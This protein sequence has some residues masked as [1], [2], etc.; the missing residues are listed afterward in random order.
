MTKKTKKLII[1][2]SILVILVGV[3]LMVLLLNYKELNFKNIKTFLNN[4][5]GWCIVA[6]FVCMLV[7]IVAEGFAIQLIARRL[8]HKTKVHQ[9]L[10][11]STAD[12]YY[13]A[14][15]PSSSGGQP[16]SLFYM[17]RDGMSVGVAGF[18]LVLNLLAYSSAII[19]IG[20]FAFIAGPS[21]FMRVDSFL[22]RVLIIIGFVF[23][24]LLL[25]LILAC[26][27]FS[28]VPRKI[29]NA[30]IKLGAKMHIIKKPQKWHDKWN[31]V[32]EK[33]RSCRETLKKHWVLILPVL[34]LNLLQRVAQTLTPCFVCHAA[35][36]DTSLYHLF[37]VQAFVLLGYNSL[38]LPGG[39]GAFEYLY[40]N[41]YHAYFNEAFIL[42][43]MMVSRVISF[44]IRTILSGLY[45]LAYHAAGLRKLKGN[46]PLAVA[47]ADAGS[48]P[49][50][51]SAPPTGAEEAQEAPTEQ[52]AQVAE[53]AQETDA[54]QAQEV[55]AQHDEEKPHAA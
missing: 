45:T 34:L 22:A 9:G 30:L 7:S 21:T 37:I 33:Y 52:E 13:S 53:E 4:S 51:E 15:T 5:R 19:I 12:I 10:A 14:I 27:L 31:G 6:A 36:P 26:M 17:A 54:E 42:S 8:G 46:E 41:A 24:A 50:G 29:G 25:L 20:I 40:L 28:R 11:Y 43:A 1:N 32:I 35:A 18:T 3:T 39:V 55:Q 49:V 2:I 47:A 48:I 38:P 23:Q 16:A 44:Y